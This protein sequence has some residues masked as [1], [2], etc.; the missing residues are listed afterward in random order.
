MVDADG[1][2][3]ISREAVGTLYAAC[4]TFVRLIVTNGAVDAITTVTVRT[5]RTANCVKRTCVIFSSKSSAADL[6]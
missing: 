5:G 4:L 1:P 3:D 2:G 6:L